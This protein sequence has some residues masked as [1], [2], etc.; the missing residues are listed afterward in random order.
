MVAS[1]RDASVSEVRYG[2]VGLQGWEA[3]SSRSDGRVA[4]D[5]VRDSGRW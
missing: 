3:E 2:A 5:A 4:C 1:S